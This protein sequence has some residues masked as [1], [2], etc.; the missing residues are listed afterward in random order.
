[1]FHRFPPLHTL[2]AFEATARHLSFAKAAEELFLSHSA[3][4][5]RI[6]IL[7]EHLDTQ[8][9]LRLNRQVVLTPK[10]ETFLLTVRDTLM[11]LHHAVAAL[12]QNACPVLRISVLPA[13]A[14]GWLIQHVGA[15]HRLHPEIDLEI[16]TTGELVNLAAGEADLGI[17]FGPGHWPGLVL[18]KLFTEYMFPVASPEY[19][20]QIGG[21]SEPAQLQG[22]VLLRHRRL[23]WKPWFDVAGL[24]WEEPAVGPTYSDMG[25]MI[26]AAASGHGVA[27]G[28]STLTAAHLKAGRLVRLT[29]IAAPS[30]WSFYLAHGPDAEKRAEVLAFK[31][32]IMEAASAH[33]AGKAPSRLRASPMPA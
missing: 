18:T 3:V 10:G 29:E 25:V 20:G 21:I 19:L 11:R 15:F 22:A 30:D 6:R 8:L 14:A 26:E 12:R 4:S 9:F 2:A 28:R 5:H 16:Q 31:S 17:R 1:M 7:E 13:F 33:R 27:L 23:P 24:K 32:W